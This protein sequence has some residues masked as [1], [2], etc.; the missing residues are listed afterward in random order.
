VVVLAM[1]FPAGQA[2]PCTSTC[3]CNTGSAKNV[4]DIWPNATGVLCGEPANTCE[5]CTICNQAYPKCPCCNPIYA[6]MPTRASAA[7][8]TE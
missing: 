8:W 5:V 6:D 3:L 2:A 4:P 7:G 1:R